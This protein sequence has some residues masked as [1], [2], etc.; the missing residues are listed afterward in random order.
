[1]EKKQFYRVTNLETKEGLWYNLKGEFSGIIQNKFTFCKNKDLN[2]DFDD[3]FLGYMSAVDSLDLLFLW[4]TK[5][6]IFSTRSKK[7]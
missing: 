4:F 2:M 1:M 7:I 5:E 3:N 6:G